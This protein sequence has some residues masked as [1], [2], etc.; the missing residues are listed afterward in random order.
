MPKNPRLRLTPE[1]V[2]IIRNDPR[3]L[4]RLAPLAGF[5]AYTSLSRVLNRRRA[6]GGSPLLQ[7]RLRQLA[8]V[9]NFT[10]E[11]FELR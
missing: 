11:P 10:G 3:G 6:H 2:E 7:Q 8:Q 4:I 1:F 9:L 5:P